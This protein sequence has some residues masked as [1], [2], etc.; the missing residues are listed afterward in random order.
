ME[1]R[2]MKA[3]NNNNRHASHPIH[4]SIHPSLFLSLLCIASFLAP[5]QPATRPPLPLA[6]AAA[7]WAPCP[8]MAR[9]ALLPSLSYPACS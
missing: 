7:N 9:M 6:A 4:P 5:G 2:K 3:D 1:I 8:N